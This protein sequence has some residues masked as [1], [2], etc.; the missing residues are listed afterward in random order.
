MAKAT[1]GIVGK[2]L[3]YRRIGGPKKPQKP[4]RPTRSKAKPELPEKRQLS[5]SFPSDD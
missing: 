2:R 4:A 5:L 3:T 1:K